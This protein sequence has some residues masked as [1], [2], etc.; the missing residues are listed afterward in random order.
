MKFWIIYNEQESVVGCE[1]TK[2]AAIATAK[3]MGYGPGEFSIQWLEVEVSA[4]SLRL[5]LG[6]L[7]GYAKDQGELEPQ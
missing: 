6:E 2:R 3:G 5:L 4:E 7:G 1:P